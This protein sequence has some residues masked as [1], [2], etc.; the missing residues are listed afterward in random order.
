[1]R[2]HNEFPQVHPII[3]H[4]SACVPLTYSVHARPFLQKHWVNVKG[5]LSKADAD[6]TAGLMR[7]NGYVTIVVCDSE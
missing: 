5:S 7:M 6:R 4:L 3:P 2:N 1:M